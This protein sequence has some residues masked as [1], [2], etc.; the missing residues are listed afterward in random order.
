MGSSGV[1]FLRTAR[2]IRQTGSIRCAEPT[3]LL[4]I[5]DIRETRKRGN[6]FRYKYENF[7]QARISARAMESETIS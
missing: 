3:D 6:L 4:R 1:G 5:F 7:L 2:I